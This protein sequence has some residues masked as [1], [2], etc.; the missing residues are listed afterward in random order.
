MYNNGTDDGPEREAIGEA[1]THG[2]TEGS[3][4]DKWTTSILFRVIKLALQA[5][6]IKPYSFRCVIGLRRRGPRWCVRADSWVARE[7][8]RGGLQKK[9]T[10]IRKLSVPLRSVG[11]SRTDI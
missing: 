11:D 2:R 10:D 5:G 1:N 4:C 9:T 3:T 8:V 7:G 6:L